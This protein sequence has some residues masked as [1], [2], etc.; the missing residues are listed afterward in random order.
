MCRLQGALVRIHVL[1]HIPMQ[2][3]PD[4][5]AGF[6]H[7]EV[8]NYAR[9]GHRCSHNMAYWEGRPFYAAGLGAASYLQVRR[10]P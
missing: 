8:S 7:Y 6:E 5:P 10:V 3:W 2:A 4:C 9:P 1:A